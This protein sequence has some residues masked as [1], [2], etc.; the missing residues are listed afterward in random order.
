M[1]SQLAGGNLAAFRAK[2][3]GLLS[4]PVGGA[5]RMAEAGG[6]KKPKA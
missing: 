5:T 2:L 4:V 1:R 3:R 6:A